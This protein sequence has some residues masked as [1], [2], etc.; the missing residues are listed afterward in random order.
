M[1]ICMYMQVG[2]HI[3]VTGRVDEHWL[4]GSLQGRKGIFPASVIDCAHPG[5]SKVEEETKSSSAQQSGVDSK[6]TKVGVAQYKGVWHST[7]G[8]GVVK[9]NVAQYKRVCGMVQEGVAHYV[10]EGVAHYV[11]EGVAQ[12]S[13][14]RMVQVVGTALGS[15]CDW[16]KEYTCVLPVLCTSPYTSVLLLLRNHETLRD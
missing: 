5:L 11:Q 9:R 12:Y 10:Q 14:N 13:G 1:Y 4:E 3:T 15:I 8:C 7:R 2:E 6:P 16:Y